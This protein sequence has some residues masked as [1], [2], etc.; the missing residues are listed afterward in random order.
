MSKKGRLKA[1]DP[2][3]AANHHRKAGVMTSPTGP[4]TD[5]EAILEGMEDHNIE[6]LEDD[7]STS[8]APLSPEA[9]GALVTST[10]TN[11]IALSWMEQGDDEDG[12]G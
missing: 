4:I 1:R 3:H 7:Y 9:L 10:L 8:S 2:F 6:G 11:G 12:A 5:T